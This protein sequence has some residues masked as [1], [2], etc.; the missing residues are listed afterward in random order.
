MAF[1]CWQYFQPWTTSSE[2]CNG[3]L[4]LGEEQNYIA[5]LDDLGG[6]VQCSQADGK[7]AR[8]AGDWGDRGGQIL[9]VGGIQQGGEILVLG[10]ETFETQ[11]MLYDAL[12]GHMVKL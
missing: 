12:S 11:G 8:N 4:A 10:E 2:K 5:A 6:D 1:W 9:A 3:V 7:I